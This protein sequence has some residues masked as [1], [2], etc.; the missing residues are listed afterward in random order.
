MTDLARATPARSLAL[1]QAWL[2]AL[3]DAS[4]SRSPRWMLGDASQRPAD[5]ALPPRTEVKAGPFGTTSDVLA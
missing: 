1:R 5:D 4:I 3:E 2:A